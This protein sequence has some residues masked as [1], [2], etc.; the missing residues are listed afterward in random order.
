MYV[1]IKLVMV[2]DML[3]CMSEWMNACICIVPNALL[4]LNAIVIVRAGGNLL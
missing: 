4:K 1:S 2:L 3:M